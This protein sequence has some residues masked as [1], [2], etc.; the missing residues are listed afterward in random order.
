[1]DTSPMADE[2]Q[3][4]DYL[5]VLG[6]WRWV[7]VL[8]TLISVITSGILSYFVLPPVYETKVTLMV[9][10]AA[11][12]ETVN[13]SQEG[14]QALVS[15][16]SRLPELTL[17]TYVGQVTSPNV[18][19][20]VIAGLKLDP[21]KFTVPRLE[22]MIS[23]RTIKDTNLIQ[24][25]VTDTDPQLAT[26]L[27]NTLAKEFPNYISE[28]NQEQLGKSVQLLDNQIQTVDKDLAAATKKLTEFNS[29]PRG[30]GYLEQELKTKGDDLN[31]YQSMLMQA[32]VEIQ[33]LNA[34]IARA[35]E[36]LRGTPRT[37]E[38]SSNKTNAGPASEV[39]PAW[40]S[41]SQIVDKKRVELAEKEAQVAALSRLV[42]DLD[43]SL[44]QLQAELT[45]KRAEQTN[46]QAEVDR[47]TNTRTL[48][49][50]K[51]TETKIVRSVNLGDTNILV[52][53]PALYPNKPVKPNKKLNMAVAGILGL[54]VSV[55]L[56]FL[57]EYLDNTVKTPSDVER[58][59]GV[60]VLGSI[61][62]MSASDWKR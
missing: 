47:L 7:L 29:Q 21:N 26:N 43:E 28:T 12:K 56:A 31:R 39:N 49:A 51:S 33:L 24:I 4:R 22:G 55:G 35:E 30:V 27:A 36:S 16:L 53:A 57:L 61:P 8:V 3:L 19:N 11:A 23:T 58:L 17:N 38:S 10:N 2:I 34:G 40:V 15:S 45:A 41:L 32:Q 18:L 42:G 62:S 9:T 48:L 14:L 60:P 59:L 50:S 25:T 46:L 6:K 37:F 13:R 44:K 54:M 1:M 20:R 5:K 52:V